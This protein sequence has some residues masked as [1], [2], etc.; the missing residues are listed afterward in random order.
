MVN[1]L[2]GGI[3]WRDLLTSSRDAHYTNERC[4][5]EANTLMGGC[6]HLITLMRGVRSCL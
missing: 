2:M 4:K 5:V 1:M 3:E 6:S